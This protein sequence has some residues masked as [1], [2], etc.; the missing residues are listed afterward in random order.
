[1][2]TQKLS[3]QVKERE[4]SIIGELARFSEEQLNIVPFEGSWTGGQVAEHLLKSA[5]V[6]D[7]VFGHTAPTS[8]PPDE[9]VPMLRI[10]LDFSIKMKSP[11]FIIP[12]DGFHPKKPLI[13]GLRGRCQRM[14]EPVGNL[15]PRVT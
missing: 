12:S 5:G 1:M 10:F 14:G 15:D 3:G 4:P 13:D 8:R 7:V 11:D 9:K 2:D 6:A